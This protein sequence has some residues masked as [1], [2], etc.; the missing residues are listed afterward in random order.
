MLRGHDKRACPASPARRRKLPADALPIESVVRNPARC[1]ITAGKGKRHTTAQSRTPRPHQSRRSLDTKCWPTARRSAGTSTPAPW[2]RNEF[3]PD[4]LQF[5][6]SEMAGPP[7]G[8]DRYSKLTVGHLP[9]VI[10]L[11]VRKRPEFRE[12]FR[13]FAQSGNGDPGNRW[14]HGSRLR[15]APCQSRGDGYC[16]LYVLM[17]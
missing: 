8:I 11:R 14:Q 4:L 15:N 2:Q 3:T 12:L 6:L 17:M 5:R 13:K 9:P 7:F 16:S 1:K 10:S